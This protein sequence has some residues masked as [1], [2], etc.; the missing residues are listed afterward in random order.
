MSTEKILSEREKTHG[1]FEGVSELAQELKDA[2]YILGK[3]KLDGGQQIALDMIF[4]KIARIM[5]G[6]PNHADHWD[7]IAGYA[8]LGKGENESRMD[9]A[10]RIINDALHQLG[11]PC[12][13]CGEQ[14]AQE[15]MEVIFPE[16]SYYVCKACAP[17]VRS[18]TPGANEQ[19]KNSTSS[20][21]EHME[22]ETRITAFHGCRKCNKYYKAE[23][24]HQTRCLKDGCERYCAICIKCHKEECDETK[25]CNKCAQYDY[26]Q[27]MRMR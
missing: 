15:G 20:K 23:D 22:R 5:W 14:K 9:K 7:D 17:E 3:N 18:R 16:A 21:M 2:A 8:M 1:D 4:L 13:N 10:D 6:D 11:Y 24:M 25:K 27:Q 12:R 19:D 26:E